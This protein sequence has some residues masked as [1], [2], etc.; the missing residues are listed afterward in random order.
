MIGKRYKLANL[1]YQDLQL[2]DLALSYAIDNSGIHLDDDEK[3]NRLKVILSQ[4][5]LKKMGK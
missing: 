5:L 1:D 2:L 3:K 4:V